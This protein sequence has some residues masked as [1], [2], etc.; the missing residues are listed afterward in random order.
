LKTS[1]GRAEC[2][3]LWT[4]MSLRGVHVDDEAISN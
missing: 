3:A 4:L 1:I 2:P